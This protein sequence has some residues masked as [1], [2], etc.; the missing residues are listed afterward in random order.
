ME[1]SSVEL[2]SLLKE[3]S[4]VVL[5]DIRESNELV[6]GKIA[7]AVH[8]PGSGLTFLMPRLDRNKRYVIICRQGKRSLLMTKLMRS[9]GFDVISL[10]GG[11][12]ALEVEYESLCQPIK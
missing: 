4:S 1:I 9:Y 5:L 7:G 11:Y 2:K 3:D 8:I 12:H 6:N 10:N